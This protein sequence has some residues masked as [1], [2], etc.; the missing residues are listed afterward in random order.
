MN[1]ISKE[2]CKDDCE[3]YI[4]DSH[5]LE[6]EDNYFDLIVSRNVTWTLYNP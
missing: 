5:I 2:N 6:F 1:I 3:F 4:M